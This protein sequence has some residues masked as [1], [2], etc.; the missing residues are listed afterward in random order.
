M[1]TG[2]HIRPEELDT[3]FN[4]EFN[5]LLRGKHGVGKTAMIKSC[6]ERN[7]LVRNESYLYFSTPTMDP[8]TD[9][10]GVPKAITDKDN[11]QYLDFIRPKNLIDGKIVA[12]FFDEYNRSAAK[13]RNAIMEL[14]QF[15][16]INGYKFPNLKVVW[17]AINPATEDEIYDVQRTDPAQEDR[18]HTLPI[19]VPYECN[20]EYFVEKYGNMIANAAIEWWNDLPEDV[21]DSVSPR[22][23]DYALTANSKNINL[24]LILPKSSNINK[25]TQALR[26]GPVL[27]K[28]ESFMNSKDSSGAR[29][30]LANNNNLNS[31]TKYILENKEMLAFFLPLF[32]KEQLA[33]LISKNDKICSYV[34]SN[35]ANVSVYN[36]LMAEIMRSKDPGQK[37]LQKKLRDLWGNAMTKSLV[38][39]LSPSAGDYSPADPHFNPS[40][41]QTDLAAIKGILDFSTTSA[42]DTAFNKVK[43]NLPKHLTGDDALAVLNVLNSITK[44]SFASTLLSPKYELLA[45]VINHCLVALRDNGVLDPKKGHLIDC[46][47][48]LYPSLNM[49][50]TKLKTTNKL[51]TIIRA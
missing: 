41:N 16:S 34:S 23:L 39:D 4:A 3:L 15:K 51:S 44:E 24:D 43:N 20:R 36:E 22:R 5:V 2:R 10:V 42:R 30:F 17:A 25:L 1:S 13:V 49:M 28:L 27:D 18:Y 9:L 11:R 8:W 6:F 26:I 50:R 21:R 48:D 33:S 40:A 14:I 7:G 32:P 47:V 35:A 37:E 45:G 46:L 38:S 31:S 12:I 29:M 19:D